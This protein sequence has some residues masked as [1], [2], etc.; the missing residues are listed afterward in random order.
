[1]R[2]ADVIEYFRANVSETAPVT[3]I[4]D[5]LGL[6]KSAVSRWGELVPQHR[7]PELEQFTRE[8][9]PRK[10]LRY[11]PSVYVDHFHNRGSRLK[12]PKISPQR[13][14]FRKSNRENC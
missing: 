3:A 8:R 7:A 13:A 1:M 14:K 10:P 6:W 4:A 9:F 5:A 11:D 2:T 12:T